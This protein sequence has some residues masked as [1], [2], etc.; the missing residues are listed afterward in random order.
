MQQG[1][2]AR[3]IPSIMTH[4]T[5]PRLWSVYARAHVR[6]HTALCKV[7]SDASSLTEWGRSV[8]YDANVLRLAIEHDAALLLAAI[9]TR[10]ATGIAPRCCA[11]GSC[12][13]RRS[14]GSSR[15]NGG[16]GS[17]FRP[18]TQSSRRPQPC[19]L[20]RSSNVELIATYVTANR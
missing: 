14:A 19:F 2:S 12:Q 9:A 4:L 18:G 7:A 11:C 10:T 20:L 6:A 1:G 5:R 16:G 13:A 15:V 17:K 8:K 3:L